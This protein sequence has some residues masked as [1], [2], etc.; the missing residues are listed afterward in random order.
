[1][2]GLRLAAPTAALIDATT[3]EHLGGQALRDAIDA[4]A[5]RA[6]ALPNGIVFH[7][8]TPTTASVVDYLGTVASGRAVA[9]LD[10]HLPGDTVRSWADRFAPAALNGV[11]GR[12]LSSEIFAET[13]DG[14]VV[15]HAPIACLDDLVAFG[16]RGNWA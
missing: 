2:T 11:D 3:G 15:P 14:R 12:V 9:L 7:G 6:A 5:L 10:P 1:M 8:I 4:A 16:Y 13:P